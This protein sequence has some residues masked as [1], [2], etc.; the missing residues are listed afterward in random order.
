MSLFK[1]FSPS[2]RFVDACA[3]AE[4]G[5]DDWGRPP[6]PPIDAKKD[7]LSALSDLYAKI[8]R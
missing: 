7:K 4:G 8:G 3:A 5:A 6:L 2:N 1:Q